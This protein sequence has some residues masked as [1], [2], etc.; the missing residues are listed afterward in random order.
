MKNRA[1]P[2]SATTMTVRLRDGARWVAI[3]PL[4]ARS[5][6]L[7]VVRALKQ[8]QLAGGGEEEEGEE[9]EEEEKKEKKKEK[10]KGKND[11]EDV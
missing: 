8:K 6:G 1:S 3:P 5:Q 4:A 9:E 10:K 2:L 7:G 11:R